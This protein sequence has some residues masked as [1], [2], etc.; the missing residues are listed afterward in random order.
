TGDTNPL[1]YPAGQ[2]VEILN[3]INSGAIVGTFGGMA[4]GSVINVNGEAFLIYYTGGNGNDVVLTSLG[5]AYPVPPVGGPFT[6]P[7]AP[8]V[9][10]VNDDWS[11]VSNGTDADNSDTPAAAW[12]TTPGQGV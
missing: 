5:P 3:K 12:G 10:F 6:P 8:S 4:D 11:S 2:S 9:V 7:G 1:T